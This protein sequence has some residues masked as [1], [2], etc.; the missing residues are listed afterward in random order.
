MKP[1]RRGMARHRT[2]LEQPAQALMIA[3]ACGIWSVGSI[4]DGGDP[5]AVVW[6]GAVCA[7]LCRARAG[8]DR[9][10]PLSDRRSR[11]LCVC[12]H[13]DERRLPPGAGEVFVFD[14]RDRLAVALRALCRCG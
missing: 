9:A 4:V 1:E 8:G 7:R 3:A 13:E 11:R 6:R 2:L 14:R 10:Y 5:F 12:L